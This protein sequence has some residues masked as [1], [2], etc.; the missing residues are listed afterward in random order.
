MS[1]QKILSIVTAVGLTLGFTPVAEANYPAAPVVVAPTVNNQIRATSTEI[2]VNANLDNVQ[3]VTV[4][5]NGKAVKAEVTSDGKI[6]V[7]TLIGPKDKVDVKIATINGVQDDVKVTKPEEPI[8]L[9]NVNF[10]VNSATLSKKARALLDQVARI[11][12]DKGFKSVS[13]IGFTDPDGS[14]AYNERLSL[15][16]ARAVEDYLSL[17]GVKV[18]FSVDAQAD[19][20]PVADNNTKQGKALNRRVEIVVG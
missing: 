19:D 9:A 6:V 15:T 8:S 16:R 18:K 20:N 12:K 17:Q 14:R 13:L 7:G 1:K 5:V 2:Q 10:A 3:S 11:V 4:T